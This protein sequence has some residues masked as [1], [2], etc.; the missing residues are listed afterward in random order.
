MN[1]EEIL[2]NKDF[3]IAK[4]KAEIQKSD[5]SSVLFDTANKAMDNGIKEIEVLVYEVTIDEKRNP[6]M[7]N[8]YKNGYVLNH[9]VGMRYVKI[10]LCYKSSL[11][12]HKEENDAWEK[13]YPMVLNKDV[14]DSRGWF[15]AVTEAKNIEG[16]AVVKGSNFLTPVLS[17]AENE[18]GSITVKTAISPASIIDSHG[19]CHIQGI[20]KKSLNENNYNLL[21]QEHDMDFDKV[22][23]DSINNEFKVYTEMV[24]IKTLLSKFKKKNIEPLKDT[25]KIEPS[26]DTQNKSISHLL[27]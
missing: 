14:A 9:S 10:F 13:Y 23:A 1:I 24:E 18:D 19:D 27:I 5:Y 26:T 12:E 20:W 25:Q 6:F 11:P 22:I 3:L 21:L 8:Q 16:S 2:A 7:F 17:M 15:W 4:K